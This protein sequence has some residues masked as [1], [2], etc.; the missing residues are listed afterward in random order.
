MNSFAHFLFL[1]VRKKLFKFYQSIVQQ[2]ELHLKAKLFQSV[3]NRVY[4]RFL[5]CNSN[6]GYTVP[7]KAEHEL[8]CHN[9]KSDDNCL[10]PVLLIYG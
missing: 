7:R 1:K 10:H 6:S 4:F 5:G 8:M 3:I 2:Q 9:I